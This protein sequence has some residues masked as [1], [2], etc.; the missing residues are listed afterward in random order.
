MRIEPASAV[1]GDIA[2]PGDKSLSHRAL[3]LGAVADGESEIGG[4]GASKDTLST[5]AAVRALDASVEVEGER[6]RVVGA[7]LRGLREPAGPLDCGNA[8]TLMRLLPGVLAGQEGRRFELVGDDSLSRRPLERIAEP[9]RAMGARVETTEGHAP[10][11]VEGSELAPVRWELAVASAQVKSCV[12]LAGLYAADGPTTAVEPHPSRDHTERLLETMGARVRRKPGAA[13]VWPVAGLRPLRL[14]I[15]GDVS[16]AA[17]FVLAATLLAGSELRLHGVGINPTRT[18]FLGVLERMGARIALF[19]RRTAGGEPVADLEVEA[20]ELTA[21]AVRPEEVPLLVDELPLFALAAGMA[22]GTSLVTGAA[23]LRVK[24][25]DRIE[26]VKA[27]LRPLGVHIE[28]FPDG[29]RVRGVPAR[30]RGGG[31]VDAAGDHR[32]AMLGAVAGLVS[33]EGVELRGAESA[34][35]SFPDFFDMLDSL[36]L[37]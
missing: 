6:V 7:G 16:A 12:L 14:D 23:E 13:A 25:S 10:L 30:P 32:I 5:V 4:F 22:R 18:G 21:T 3:I 8:G 15:P 17:P 27:A 33:R 37:R 34:A 20:A 19:N 24:E 1:R 28:A 9:L 36:V 29:F 31:V 2:V 11:T 26:T 35:V